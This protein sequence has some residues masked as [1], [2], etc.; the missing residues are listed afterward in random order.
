ML[1]HD[2]VMTDRKAEPG[3]LPA[4]LVVKK[5]LN[6]FSRHLGEI[7]VPLSRILISTRSPRLRLLWSPA[8]ARNHCS[9][10]VLCVY[11]LHRTHSKS[12]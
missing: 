6:I 12:D 4:G 7:P 9:R 3:A 2:N 5:G 8:S 1:L 11:S 10:S